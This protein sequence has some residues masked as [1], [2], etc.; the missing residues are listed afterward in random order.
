MSSSV[1]ALRIALPLLLTVSIAG[2]KVLGHSDEPTYLAL[3]DSYT[4]GQDVEPTDRWPVQLVRMLRDSGVKVRDPKLIAQ[5]GWTTGELLDAM[6]EQHARGTFEMVTLL[7]GVNNQYRGQSTA[8][9]RKQFQEVLK[10]TI[11][12]ASKRPTHVIVLSIPDWGV[13]PFADGQDRAKISREIDAYNAVVAEEA[14]RAGAT[15]IDIT[16]ISRQAG[17]DRSLVAA[18]GLHPSAKMYKDWAEQ[19]L[20][21]AKR[22]VSGR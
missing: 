15:F 21:Q 6:H 13:M 20:P 3:G 14:K 9:F 8:E 11:A 16:T 2:C 10:E 19:L 1:L 17:D 18:D 4:I 5:T 7:V 12:R 22:I